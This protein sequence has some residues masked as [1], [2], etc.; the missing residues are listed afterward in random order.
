L[1]AAHAVCNANSDV[2][3]VTVSV[4]P[5]MQREVFKTEPPV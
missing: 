1:G 4:K 3:I 2:A 5:A